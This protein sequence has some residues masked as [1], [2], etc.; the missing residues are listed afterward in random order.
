VK[1]PFLPSPSVWATL[2]RP[3]VSN[4]PTRPRLRRRKRA[5]TRFFLFHLP[6]TVLVR[7]RRLARRFPELLSA[8]GTLFF[9]T[10]SLYFEGWCPCSNSR[11]F[12]SADSQPSVPVAKC[13]PVPTFPH[14]GSPRITLRRILVFLFPAILSFGV[15]LYGDPCFPRSP[16]DYS[17][18]PL[19]PF[20]LS[21]SPFPLNR[22]QLIF[23]P[24]PRI[25]SS[26]KA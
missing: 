20:F 11:A 18:P 19:P 6:F 21:L 13:S 26:L 12:F 3:L 25:P 15:R 4:S 23:S 9:F 7:R 1:C 24:P 17:F 2:V 8:V 5:F 14:C 22:M 16:Y 10:F